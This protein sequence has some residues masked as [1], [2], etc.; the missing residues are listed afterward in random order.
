MEEIF[1]I[2]REDEIN[3]NE[4]SDQIEFKQLR[5]LT[6]EYVPKF[7]SFCSINCNNDVLDTPTPLF[8]QKVAFPSLE[9]IWNKDQRKMFSFK[10]LNRVKVHHCMSMRYMFPISIAKSLLELEQLSVDNCGVE[11]IVADDQEANIAV[12]FVFPRITSLEINYLPR[13]KTFYRGIHTLQWPNLKRLVMSHCDKVELFASELFNFQENNEGQRDESS[14][15]PLFIVEKDTFPSLKEIKISESNN[16]KIGC[17]EMKYFSLGDVTTPI[18]R[19]F[20]LEGD[21]NTTIQLI[22]DS[23]VSHPYDWKEEDF[24]DLEDKDSCNSKDED[25]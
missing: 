15:Q 7:K 18:L 11:E 13:L 12:T 6:L 14:V 22:Q 2:E 17:P 5:W 19:E 24:L 10:K 4:G 9:Q 23:R 20:P 21:L 16:L 1:A 25:Y 3:N 8:N